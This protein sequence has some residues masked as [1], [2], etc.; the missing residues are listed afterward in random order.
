MQ[1]HNGENN[2]NDNNEYNEEYRESPNPKLGIMWE[3]LS[4]QRQREINKMVIT[5]I[6]KFEVDG[7]LEVDKIYPL[8]L[9]HGFDQ[10]EPKQY[11]YLMCAFRLTKPEKPIMINQNLPPAN[12]ILNIAMTDI[13]VFKEDKMFEWIDHV[14]RINKQSKDNKE[15]QLFYE[16]N[17]FKNEKTD[18]EKNNN[19]SQCN[20]N[21]PIDG[22]GLSIGDSDVM[23]GVVDFTNKPNDTDNTPK[24]KHNITEKE[25]FDFYEENEKERDNEEYVSIFRAFSRKM[26]N[27][28]MRTYYSHK[29]EDE[30][31]EEDIINI[32]HCLKDLQMTFSKCD[33][34]KFNKHEL[35]QLGFINW[36]DEILLIPVWAFPVILNNSKDKKVYTPSNSEIFVRD[37]DINEKPITKYGCVPFGFKISEIKL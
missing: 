33:F 17:I 35:G 36:S 5:T 6:K 4:E 12:N 30:E 13:E 1:E 19:P 9:T 7:K 23:I 8:E 14:N 22:K 37:I 18:S 21:K 27:N 29:I 15:N 3:M 16:D 25:L 11:V 24:V 28:T 31:S 2:N 32:I 26:V 34:W 20:I 10:E